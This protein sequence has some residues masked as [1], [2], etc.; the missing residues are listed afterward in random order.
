KGASCEMDIGPVKQGP[1]RL[2]LWSEGKERGETEFVVVGPVEQ[3]KIGPLDKD[4]FQ[5]REVDRIE[6]VAAND[7]NRYYSLNPTY[8]KIVEAP[9]IGKFL[10]N[11]APLTG[12]GVGGDHEWVSYRIDNLT[13][14]KPHLLV[15]EYP[16]V[17]DA[18]VGISFLDNF[19]LPPD[20]P[21]DDNGKR[22][23][24]P[25]A[26][27]KFT[28]ESGKLPNHRN[29][30]SQPPLVSG[31]ITGNGL[32]ITGKKQS[33][34]AV[35]Y[36]GDDWGVVHFDNYGYM[37]SSPIRLCRISVHEITND[38]PMLE[39]SNL[40]ND[41]IFGHY[42][43]SYQAIQTSSFNPTAMA[44]G[45]M[46]ASGWIQQ[47]KHYKWYYQAAE[48]MVKYMRFRG[49]NTL[50]AG[51]VRYGGAAQYNSQY[52]QS[53][54]NDIDLTALYARVFE[55]ND[56]TLVP[57]TAFISTFPL[58]LRDRY[59]HYD[60]A[61]RGADTILQVSGDGY[62]TYPMWG[63]GRAV[64]PLH[65]EV[66]KEMVGLARELAERYRDYP[67][68]KGVMYI[69]SAGTGVVLPSYFA[70]HL[71][72]KPGPGLNYE[73]VNYFSTYD[74][75]T[76]GLFEKRTGINVPVSN[77]DPRRFPKRREWLLKNQKKAWTDFRCQ[78]IADSWAALGKA[79]KEAAP[80]MN[81]YTA[82]GEQTPA[83]VYVYEKKYASYLDVLKES[84]AGVAAPQQSGACVI[85]YSFNEMFGHRL[86]ASCKFSPD[87]LVRFNGINFDESVAPL[88]DRSENMG[89]YMERQFEENP[90]KMF[91]P[92]RP[93]YGTAGGHCRYLLAGNRGSM[94]D[95][96]V[97]LSRCTPLYISH[98]WVDGGVPQG[99][100]EQFREF[101]AAYRTI[102]LGKYDT[103]FSEGYPGITVRNTR[104]AKTGKTYFYAV[105]TDSKPRTVNV[106]VEGE[107]KE[108][109][110][111]YPA[112]AREGK[113]WPIALEPYA[114]RVF[115]IAGGRL[116]EIRAN[117]Q[118]T[119]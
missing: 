105:N 71:Y 112:L 76:M 37:R 80:R 28:L 64:N 5:L 83:Q 54:A 92:E 97:I 69:S 117:E 61:T 101:G 35:F 44:I 81:M 29:R 119:K 68:V 9:G 70:P 99:H 115:E 86:G 65:P 73:N 98:Y 46:S 100:D 1:Y 87:D 2:E 51:A 90:A 74:D 50:F 59:T 19:F 16:D 40:S 72:V 3:R 116:V 75:Y 25:A 52:A 41:R 110:A 66:R 106:T 39:S 33:V 34:S 77:D 91:P 47:G 32:P 12:A 17:G 84:G 15:V 49:E 43:E 18:M 48:R 67:A 102:P 23:I 10:V 36:P 27:Y 6:C 63:R 108:R 24:T 22:I 8:D 111:G 96:A 31:F 26:L 30:K 89:V 7:K 42:T 53:G 107:L 93:W 58:R 78:G 114:L 21:K 56:L 103:V 13:P 85:G 113:E 60:V 109:T 95:Y 79:V 14:D 62:L 57:T 11:D 55:E 45:E 20:L 4:V 118:E 94:V 82:E 88:L 104:D 38:I